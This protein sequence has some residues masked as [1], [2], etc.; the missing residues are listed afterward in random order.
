[1]NCSLAGRPIRLFVF[2]MDGVLV[3]TS[4]GHAQAYRELWETLGVQG[5]D[6]EQIAGRKTQEVIA[7]VT[8]DLEPSREQIADWTGIKQRRA[9][10]L[11]GSGELEYRDTRACLEMLAGHG[12]PMALGTAASRAATGDILR[13]LG[14]AGFFSC[15]ATAEDTVNGKPAPD[16]YRII[17]DTLGIPPGSTLVVE[18][19]HAGLLAAQAAGTLSVSVRSGLGSAQAD[20]LGIFPDLAGLQR[21]L[22]FHA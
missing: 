14:L 19:S 21:A 16:V 20:F 7:E 11:L 8:A 10:E 4:P 9:R 22:E 17:T 18:D 3:S 6:Y 2:D 13:R 5:P 1:M 15:V 12:M